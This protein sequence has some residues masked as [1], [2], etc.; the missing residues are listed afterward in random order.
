[1]IVRLCAKIFLEV[2]VGS[3]LC[4]LF[5]LLSSLSRGLLAFRGLLE[6]FFLFF[7]IVEFWKEEILEPVSKL[8]IEGVVE[9]TTIN[10]QP[11]RNLV[12]LFSN[13]FKIEGS[14]VKFFLSEYGI[15]RGRTLDNFGG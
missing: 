9:N 11:G 2:I 6:L 13:C 4:F 8:L 14:F 7:L 1:M 3:G 5:A 10:L 12:K 15:V